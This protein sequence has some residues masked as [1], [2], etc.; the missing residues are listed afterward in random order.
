MRPCLASALT[1]LSLLLIAPGAAAQQLPRGPAQRGV[2]A[3][4]APDI[5]LATPVGFRQFEVLSMSSNDGLGHPATHMISATVN[6]PDLTVDSLLGVA[7]IIGVRTGP[8]RFEHHY[9]VVRSADLQAGS[10]PDGEGSRVM[11]AEISSPLHL[12]ATTERDRVFENATLEG[13]VRAVVAGYPGLGLRVEARLPSARRT[14]VQHGEDDLGFLRRLLDPEGAALLVGGDG[15]SASV[16]LSDGR[17]RPQFTRRFGEDGFDNIQVSRRLGSAMSVWRPPVTPGG[18]PRVLRSPPSVGAYGGAH[19]RVRLPGSVSDE[20]ARRVLQGLSDRTL[21]TTVTLQGSLPQSGDLL[22]VEGHDDPELNRN[23]R[24][25]STSSGTHMEGTMQ[26]FG[27][28]VLAPARPTFWG[29]ASVERLQVGLER[30]HVLA[31]AN[32]AV[33]VDARGRVRIR[34]EWGPAPDGT[35][36]E[37]WVPVAGTTPSAGAGY[38]T[39]Q[40]G[41]TDAPV[42]VGSALE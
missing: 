4:E 38:V 24:V 12:L 3:S 25:L 41:R 17:G 13:V 9:G 11:H 8:R 36:P 19:A 34:F 30:V 35:Q 29:R 22:R 40:D 23:Y 5:W 33:R 42:L 16:I 1:L 39:F 20:G 37:M 7:V 32:G 10:G 31:D 27:T 14:F 26:R 28:L 6:D 21:L 2:N 18:S 15:Q